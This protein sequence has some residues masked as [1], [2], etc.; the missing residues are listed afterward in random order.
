MITGAEQMLSL[1]QVPL[2]HFY[3]KGGVGKFEK[4][5]RDTL[6]VIFHGMLLTSR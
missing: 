5:A 3:V 2:K 1:M 6:F 4:P